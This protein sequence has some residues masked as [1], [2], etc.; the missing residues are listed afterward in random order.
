MNDSTK[1]SNKYDMKGLEDL[2]CT[3]PEVSGCR[4]V[5][6]KDGKIA[7]IHVVTESAKEPRLVSRDIQSLL[8]VKADLDL[9][10]RKISVTR[11]VPKAPDGGKVEAIPTNQPGA[12]FPPDFEGDLEEVIVETDEAPR[13]LFSSLSVTH[14]RSRVMAEVTL[15]MEQRHEVGEFEAADTGDGHLTA[16]IQA[17]LQAMFQLFQPELSFDLPQFQIL[18]FG[19]ERVMVVYLSAIAGREFRSYIGSALIRQDIQQTAVLATLSALN[20]VSSCWEE[21]ASL[22]F[23]IV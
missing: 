23:E 12:E 4:F 17:T 14:A 9:D 3:I 16:V 10:F 20:R 13:V 6:G 7:E 1:S 5:A 18:T 2:A 15:S 21:Q 22:D 19:R 8:R 11:S